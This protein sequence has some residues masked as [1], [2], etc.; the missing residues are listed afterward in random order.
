MVWNIV[1]GHGAH[2]YVSS[3]PGGTTSAIY[4]PAVR[5]NVEVVTMSLPKQD[6]FRHWQRI[7]VVDDEDAQRGVISQM[8]GS[9]GCEVDTAASGEEA[10]QY[11]KNGR[12]D[13]IV[14]DTIMPPGINGRETYRR[15]IG[16]HH[17]QKAIIASGFAES[18]E[19]KEA[20]R[21]G[22]GQFIQKPYTLEKSG[23]AVEA[24]LA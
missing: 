20:L 23:L 6:Y 7:L 18:D 10:V 5:T 11:L 13:L 8:L 9:L 14:P 21:M 22:P 3:A 12:A 24:E 15:I 19:V 4:L 2:I 16:I 1:H 17:G